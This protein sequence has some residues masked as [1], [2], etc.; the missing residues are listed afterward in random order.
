MSSIESAN[1]GEV[2]SIAGTV[3]AGLRGHWRLALSAI[4]TWQS[5]IV[6]FAGW[7]V[8]L[9]LTTVVASQL[10]GAPPAGLGEL[11]R[12]SVGRW[13]A[14]WYIAIARDGY[15]LPT[16]GQGNVAFYPLLPLLI[17]LVE[18]VI[19]SWHAAG[20]IVV[21]AALL[22]A[23][24][25]LHALVRLD[26][27][28]GTALRAVAAL[29]LFPTAIFLTA[30]YTESLLLLTMIAATYH[31]RRGQWWA[32][33]LWGLAAGLTKFVGAAVAVAILWEWGRRVL[34]EGPQRRHLA[35]GLA[36]MAPVAGAL[37]FLAYLHLRFGSFQVY[38][39]VQAAWYRQSFFRP[40][41]PD[42]WGFLTAFLR[43]D[44]ATVINYFYPQVG[45]TLP[46]T[47]AFMVLD[48]AFLLIGLVVGL[49]VCLRLRASY[50]LLMLAVLAVA[51]YS[52]SP[53]SLNRI[54]LILFPLPIAF[55]LAGR[56]RPLGFAIFTLS[57]LLGV[58]HTFL[59]VN[60]Y[61]AG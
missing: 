20:A 11:V 34:R 26:H 15:S 1:V 21:N 12:Q 39:D 3:L 44:G 60:G 32:A 31:A 47:N 35:E 30:I 16:T 33:G 28:E 42:G 59:F 18:F 58:Y 19:P 17:R 4:G 2:N 45:A 55:A 8:L 13:D 36:V 40:F 41:F 14:G 38:F 22:G 61:W 53:Q 37:S 52:G 7:R 46:S 10:S 49:V 9:F 51:A 24:L 43:G 56:Y 29:L 27:D 48:L 50:G 6:L 54:A 23:V 5:A 57:G 25:Y